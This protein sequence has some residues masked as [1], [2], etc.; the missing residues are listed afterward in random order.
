MVSDLH[1]HANMLSLNRRFLE[2]ISTS[3]LGS[4]VANSIRKNSITIVLHGL[5]PGKVLA[6]V[7]G[8]D[9]DIFQ[10][11]FH[12]EGCHMNKHQICE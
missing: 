6:Q 2:I 8:L 12:K 5:K 4:Q 9:T 1:S 10:Q 11:I 7:E 3:Y